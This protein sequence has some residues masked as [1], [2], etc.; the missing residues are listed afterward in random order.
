VREVKPRGSIWFGIAVVAVFFVG[1][2]LVMGWVGSGA[3][4]IPH[5]VSDGGV[6]CTSCHPIDQLSDEHR[7]RVAGSCR[8]CH[9]EAVAAAGSPAG[10]RG[11]VM[12]GAPVDAAA[13]VTPGIVN[14][15][16][17]AGTRLTVGKLER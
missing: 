6:A 1:V 7:D 4:G 8:S 2:T 10:D 15:A 5:E 3:P 9:S 14:G 12:D 11:T 16:I 13:S 17:R